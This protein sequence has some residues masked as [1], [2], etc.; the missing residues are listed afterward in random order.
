MT[1]CEQCKFAE[2]DYETYYGTT[3]KEWFICGCK[4]DVDYWEEHEDCEEFEE[5]DYGAEI[6]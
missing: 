1:K 2:W 3:R 6:D 4:K 5:A